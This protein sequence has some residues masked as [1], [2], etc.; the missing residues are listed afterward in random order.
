MRQLVGLLKTMDVSEAKEHYFQICAH[1]QA[2]GHAVN[3]SLDEFLS[4]TLKTDAPKVF[5]EVTDKKL[6]EYMQNR[7]RALKHE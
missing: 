4:V 5:D 2:T 6:E 1:A 3:V 7:M